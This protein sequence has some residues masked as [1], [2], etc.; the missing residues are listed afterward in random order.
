MGATHILVVEDDLEI[1]DAVSQVLERAGYD[2]IVVSSGAE[3]LAF[4][5]RVAGRCLILLD[6]RMTDMDGW[7]VLSA[8]R[9][10]RRA[11][12]PVVI[13]SAVSGDALPRGLPVLAKP[14]GADDLLGVVR[15]HLPH[16]TATAA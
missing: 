14:F 12:H 6:L 8:L 15:Q 13:M 1:S 4:L 11:D 16:G 3:A 5:A 10:A 2:P 7:E 9:V